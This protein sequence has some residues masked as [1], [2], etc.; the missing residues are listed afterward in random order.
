[1]AWSI[2]RNLKIAKIENR[3]AKESTI[4]NNNNIYRY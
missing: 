1:M 2:S 4:N 3:L